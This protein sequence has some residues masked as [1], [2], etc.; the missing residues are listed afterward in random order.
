MPQKIDLSEQD[1]TEILSFW[2]FLDTSTL[3]LTNRGTSNTTYFAN[4]PA[5]KFFLK[6]YGDSTTTAQI[7]YEHSLLTYLQQA[8]LSFAVPTPIPALSGETLVHVNR[9][10]SLLR[11]ALIPLIPGQLA[12]RQNL[13][14]ANAAGRTLG[15]LHRA[16]AGFDPE[17][18]LAQLPFW[19]DLNH[20]HPLVPDPLE[21]PQSLALALE[22][23][24]RLVKI[25][26][27]VLEAMPDLYKTLPVQTIHAD[28]LSFNIL[29]EENRVVGVLDFEFATRDLRIV[30]YICGLDD[31]SMFPWKETSRW[32]FVEAFCAGY[33]E[34]ISLRQSEAE[35]ITMAWR[36]QRASSIV[37]W[38]G[39]LR[40][41]KVTY[42]KLVDA[43]ANTLLFEDWLEDNATSLL[44]YTENRGSVRG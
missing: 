12:D 4:A 17:G 42:Q 33:A 2:S 9:N 28:Y 13:R 39:W 6:L 15:E 40:E 38:T 14:H 30:D 22:Q 19:G 24:A 36:L 16:L 34:H 21:V 29:L 41:G 32:E 25:L 7:Q 23:Q 10:G 43:V 11:M 3:Q 18:Q 1:V 31:Y 27:E 8:N 5:G 20:I 37:Y 26:T 44:S 35:A